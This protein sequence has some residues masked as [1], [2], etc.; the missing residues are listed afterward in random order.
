MVYGKFLPQY[1][2]LGHLGTTK[3]LTFIISKYVGVLMACSETDPKIEGNRVLLTPSRSDLDQNV[4]QSFLSLCKGVNNCV[5]H[6]TGL[7]MLLVNY[8]LYTQYTSCSV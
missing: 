4:T 7:P 8:F 5:T 6:H 2:D 3:P 1:L